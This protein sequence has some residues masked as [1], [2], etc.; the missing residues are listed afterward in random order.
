MHNNNLTNSVVH[1]L[2]NSV[3]IHAGHYNDNNKNKILTTASF[4]S[5]SESKSKP[6]SESL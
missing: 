6:E 4:G 3:N 5:K 2:P 1:H